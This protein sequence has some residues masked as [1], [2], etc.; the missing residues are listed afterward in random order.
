MNVMVE[1]VHVPLEASSI[2]AIDAEI[3]R[4]GLELERIEFERAKLK[5]HISELEQKKLRQLEL[6][7]YK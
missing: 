6:L 5:S 4:F 2:S 3:A 7:G 1:L